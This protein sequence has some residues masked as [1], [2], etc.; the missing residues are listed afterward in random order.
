MSRKRSAEMFP[1]VASYLEGGEDVSSLCTRYGLTRGQFYYWRRKFQ[2]THEQ[3][4]GRS[5]FVPMEILDDTKV[6]FLEIEMPGGTVL[7]SNNLLPASYI[8][9]L[10]EEG[11]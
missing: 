7:R 4:N 8:R 9:S 3:A 1:I 10:M 2:Q 11:C 6:H 5:G